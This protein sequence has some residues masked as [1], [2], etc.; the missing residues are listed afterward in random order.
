MLSGFVCAGRAKGIAVARFADN[1]RPLHTYNITSYLTLTEDRTVKYD[2]QPAEK[3]AQAVQHTDNVEFIEE[4]LKANPA[5]NG[6]LGGFEASLDFNFHGVAPNKP[7][8]DTVERL[9]RSNGPKINES[10]K[11]HAQKFYTPEPPKPL[12]LDAEQQAQ[13]DTAMGFCADLGF[14][15]DNFPI[16]FVQALGQGVMGQAF[17]GEIILSRDAFV[18][19]T[20]Q[21][22]ITL[23]EE[24]I[25]LH[26]GVA[27]ESRAMQER[28]LHELVTL[29]ERALERPL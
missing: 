26:H 7:F 22:A 29:G 8:L 17:G 16:R 18:A 12:I 11:V 24:F 13:L 5:D 25:H 28:L 14:A 3:V 10:A 27:D 2:W 23:I 1:R 15:V 19:G 4:I 20:K 9:S 6:G 21:I